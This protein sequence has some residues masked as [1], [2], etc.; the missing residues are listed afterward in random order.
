MIEL[1]G[2][3]GQ[4]PGISLER[5]SVTE[6]PIGIGCARTIVQ[7]RMDRC[8]LLNQIDSHKRNFEKGTSE[9]NGAPGVCR[10]LLTDSKLEELTMMTTVRR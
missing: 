2:R 10:D 3:Q 8:L 7:L 4:M 1:W 9:L 5:L 6:S